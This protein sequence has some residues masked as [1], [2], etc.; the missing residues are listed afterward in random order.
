MQGESTNWEDVMRF[1]QL[2][3][4]AEPTDTRIYLV[5]DNHRSHHKLEVAERA[6]TLNIEFV[7]LPAG[8]PEINSI[9]ALWSVI[10][11]DFKSRL[12]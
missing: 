5:A 6:R 3:R 12:I 4:D 1:L 2:I 9:E 11:R 7:F 10:K 8:T